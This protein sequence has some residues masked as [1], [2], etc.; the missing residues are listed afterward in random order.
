MSRREQALILA[1]ALFALLRFLV[2]SEKRQSMRAVGTI[3]GAGS[4]VAT[5]GALGQ[6][7]TSGTD[8]ARILVGLAVA[9]TLATA[10]I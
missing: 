4:V 3:C 8:D 2:I 1:A 9:S 6:H 5:L 10:S 7:M